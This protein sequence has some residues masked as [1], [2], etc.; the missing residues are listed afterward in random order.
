M[1]IRLAI[2]TLVS[3]CTFIDMSMRDNHLEGTGLDL[4]ENP[5]FLEEVIEIRSNLAA[6]WLGLLFHDLTPLSLALAAG[7]QARQRPGKTNQH[8]CASDRQNGG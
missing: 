6:V 8:Y 3:F 4:F 7:H 2:A 5:L 1:F